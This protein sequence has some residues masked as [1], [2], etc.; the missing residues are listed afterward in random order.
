M[1]VIPLVFMVGH[2]CNYPFYRLST[3]NLIDFHIN[4]FSVQQFGHENER[5]KIS[6]LEGGLVYGQ[7][8]TAGP[9]QYL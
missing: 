4:R 6:V 2:S 1:E 3:F 9:G 7:Q 5:C 8:N